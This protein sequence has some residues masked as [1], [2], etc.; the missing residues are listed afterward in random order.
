MRRMTILIITFPLLVLVFFT[1]YG[2]AIYEYI[3]PKVTAF[4]VNDVIINQKA[5]RNIPKAAVDEDS[6]VYVITPQAGLDKT[7]YT[8]KKHKITHFTTPYTEEGY[9]YSKDNAIKNLMIVKNITLKEPL[10][11][12]DRVIID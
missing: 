2:E 3:T 7:F 11:D 9:L 1:F 5:Y 6:C 8:V 10:K 12:G 4:A